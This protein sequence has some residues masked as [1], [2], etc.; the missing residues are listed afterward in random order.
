MFLLSVY[1]FLIEP[2]WLLVKNIKLSLKP[3][4]RLVH[5]T[6]IHFHGDES[7]L[8]KIVSIINNLSPDFV[9]FTGD[10]VD[11]KE[12]LNQALN[13]LEKI[14]CPLFG[15]PGNHDYWSG[16]SFESINSS[17]ETTGGLWL[18]DQNTKFKDLYITGLAHETYKQIKEADK[19]FQKRLLLCHYPAIIDQI[20]NEKYD[21]IFSRTL[22]WWASSFTNIG[23]IEST[24]WCRK[25]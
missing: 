9:C 7:Y 25:I 22:P 20:E 19:S 3:Q 18:V 6:D 16:V 13:I 15:V 4:Y 11:E 12:K 2:H 5:I 1:A 21:L 8:K 14:N 24:I 17:L 10:L 23:S